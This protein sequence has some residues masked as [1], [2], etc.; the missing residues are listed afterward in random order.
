MTS[1]NS[2]FVNTDKFQAIVLDKHK[3]NSTEVRFIIDSGIIR[4]VSLVNIL[5]ITIDDKLTLF[6]TIM[7]IF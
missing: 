3:S 7:K 1:L 2:F 5:G 6:C 4:A